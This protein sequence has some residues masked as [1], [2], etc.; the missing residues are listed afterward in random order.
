MAADV[1]LVKAKPYIGVSAHTN[2][3]EVAAVLAAF[4][5]AGCNLAATHIPMIGFLVSFEPIS[6]HD[7][8]PNRYVAVDALASLVRLTIGQALPMIH[9]ETHDVTSLMEQVMA[10]YIDVLGSS[11]WP[12]LQINV[13][14]DN[15]E[16]FAVVRAINDRYPNVQIVFQL[17]ANLLQGDTQPI[18][19]EI[20]GYGQ[21][22]SYLLIDPSAGQGKIFDVAQTVGVYQCLQHKFPNLTIG[23]AGGFNG[24]TVADRI[25]K[26][27][28]QLG[29]LD[30]SIDAEGRLR[31]VN[32]AMDIA[33]VKKYIQSAVTAFS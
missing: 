28:A 21:A 8:G 2:V 19:D 20:N 3:R 22:L 12:A 11:L 13:I 32:D 6:K 7:V 26:I 25:P 23:L 29:T 18:V 31:D 4:S 27:A 24:D 5:E 9:L 30:F 10:L 1:G 15:P 16:R 14:D 17:R 33:E